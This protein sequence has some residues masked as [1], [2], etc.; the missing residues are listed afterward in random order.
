LNASATLCIGYFCEMPF[1]P[2]DRYIYA[3]L[4]HVLLELTPST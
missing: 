4:V 2:V 1:K 3:K